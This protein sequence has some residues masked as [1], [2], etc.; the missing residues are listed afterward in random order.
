MPRLC[1]AGVRASSSHRPVLARNLRTSHA[2]YEL[3]DR[4]A[5]RCAQ[6]ASRSWLVH[7]FRAGNSRDYP[8]FRSGQVHFGHV[9]H[10]G[11]S[12]FYDLHI[13]GI[14][15]ARVHRPDRSLTWR[16]GFR[17]PALHTCTWH[18]LEVVEGLIDGRR[19]TISDEKLKS[20]TNQWN[21]P[22]NYSKSAQTVYGLL[23]LLVCFYSPESGLPLLHDCTV[24]VCVISVAMGST[25]VELSSYFEPCIWT[26]DANVIFSPIDSGAYLQINL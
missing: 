26:K 24:T 19:H 18:V 5:D 20:R 8:C 7:W 13:P 2:S 17:Q 11:K 3:S 10:L 16:S 21:K 15:D 25:K 9:T 1:T 14:A 6:I 4:I 22:Y 12:Y 23:L